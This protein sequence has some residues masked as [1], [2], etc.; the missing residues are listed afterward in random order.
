MMLTVTNVDPSSR[1]SLTSKDRFRFVFDPPWGGTVVV[2]G[3]VIV[4]SQTLLPSNFAATF[5]AATRELAIRYLGIAQPFPPGDGFGVLVSFAA[6]QAVSFGTI[7]GR[8]PN[9]PGRI[10]PMLPAYVTIAFLRLPV[11]PPGPPGPQ[12]AQGPQGV[13]GI[14]GTQGVRGSQGDPG[15]QGAPGPPG[16]PGPP[17]AGAGRVNFLQVAAKRWYEGAPART[18]TVAGGPT[19]MAFDGRNIWIIATDTLYRMRASDGAVLDQIALPPV[20]F[21]SYDGR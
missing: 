16:P 1:E 20:Q 7:A 18:T 9:V 10:D 5:S 15:P 14:Q 11:G 2:V 3:P 19:A 12:G 17:G 6:P 4:N 21:G 13:Q 8:G